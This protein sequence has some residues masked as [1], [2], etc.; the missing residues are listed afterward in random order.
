MGLARQICGVKFDTF[1]NWQILNTFSTFFSAHN[2]VKSVFMTVWVIFAQKHLKTCENKTK[3]RRKYSFFWKCQF[4]P[5]KFV[6]LDPHP[7]LMQKK[8][9]TKITLVKF[10]KLTKSILFFHKNLSFSQQ[11]RP[12]VRMECLEQ[13][14]HEILW[15]KSQKN[16]QITERPQNSAQVQ[17]KC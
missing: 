12:M 4:L 6:G 13:M 15:K 14:W 8:F 9:H 1:Q 3:N 7:L 11:R 16:L 2:F 17:S 5:R 10:V